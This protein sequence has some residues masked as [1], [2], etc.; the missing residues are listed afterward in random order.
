M[1]RISDERA[2]PNVRG[3]DNKLDNMQKK[4][5]LCVSTLKFV[6]QSKSTYAIALIAVTYI[7]LHL[8]V[9]IFNA[10]KRIRHS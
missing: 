10:T 9:L 1:P 3:E 7:H 4:L 6:N 2:K 5:S 8:I